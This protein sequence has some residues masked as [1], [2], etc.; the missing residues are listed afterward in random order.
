MGGRHVLRGER[1][2]KQLLM[3]ASQVSKL[4]RANPGEKEHVA[5]EVMAKQHA[6]HAIQ[7]EQVPMPLTQWSAF[8]LR[9]SGSRISE[10]VVW[11]LLC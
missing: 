6:L 5:R 3:P 1:G 4:R 8:D 2:E 7:M 11:K 9:D 10:M